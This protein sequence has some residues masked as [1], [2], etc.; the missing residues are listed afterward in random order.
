MQ[1]PG[2]V[3]VTHGRHLVTGPARVVGQFVSAPPLIQVKGRVGH[4]EIGLE[5]RML[6]LEKGIGGHLAQIGGDTANGQIHLGQLVGSAGLLL[7]VDRDVFG[8]AVMALNKL[9]RLNEHTA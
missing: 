2:V 9:Y 8:V 4:N 5:I 3:G 6:I 7:P 1:Y